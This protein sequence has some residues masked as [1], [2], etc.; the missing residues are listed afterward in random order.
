MST[1]PLTALLNIPNVPYIS[2]NYNPLRFVTSIKFSEGTAK[3]LNNITFLHDPNWGMTYRKETTLPVSFF[4]VKKFDD[5]WQNE[6]SQKTMLFYDSGKTAEPTSNGGLMAVVSDN[7]IAKPKVYKMEVLVPFQPDACLNQY[8]FDNDI[9]SSVFDTATKT[10]SV[11][12]ARAEEAQSWLVSKLSIYN[13]VVSN[14]VALL[15]LLF[16]ALCVDLNPTS[17][18]SALLSQDAINKRSLEAMRDN[19]GIV[20]L[21]M[22]NGWKFK[23]LT[24]VD[25]DLSKSGEVDG[26][27]EG[28]ITLQELPV[29]TSLTSNKGV[30]SAGKS[31]LYRQMLQRNEAKKESVKKALNAVQNSAVTV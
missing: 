15:R 14:T 7:V 12:G 30:I 3:M 24:L 20:R 21:K 5:V 31:V 22:W 25:V 17:I 18:A 13:R 11:T 16:S 1:R 23:Y 19:R 9:I 29:I 10:Q 4:F 6:V 26:F 28:T 27:Y 2:E 8:Q